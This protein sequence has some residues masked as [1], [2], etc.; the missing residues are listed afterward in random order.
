MAGAS[1]SGTKFEHVVATTL[2]RL[3]YKD[4]AIVVWGTA[5]SDKNAPDIDAHL[6]DGEFKVEV[7]T[8]GAFEFGSNKFKYENGF[9]VLPTNDLFRSCFP[10]DFQPFGG[11]VPSFL[12]GDASQETLRRERKEQKASGNPLDVRL[13]FD[14]PFL[15]AK[16][17]ASKSIHYIQIEGLGLYRT[18]LDDPRDLGLPVLSFATQVRYRCKTHVSNKS[19]SVQ[20]QFVCLTRPLPSPYDLTDPTRLPPGFSVGSQ[21]PTMA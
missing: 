18:T 17:Y 4:S 7:K 8:K 1:A 13:S 20:T 3:R 2:Q 19:H 21:S 5:G 14:D 10:L 15:P 9:Y 11:F 6:I 16:Y 12:K